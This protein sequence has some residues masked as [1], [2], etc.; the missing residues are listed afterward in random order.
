MKLILGKLDKLSS[1]KELPPSVKY[2]S[3]TITTE[4]TEN[5]KQY[6]LNVLKAKTCYTTVSSPNWY[7][8]NTD[9]QIFW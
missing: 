4:R 7:D 6:A 3:A 1:I 9:V 5:V 2:M 8:T